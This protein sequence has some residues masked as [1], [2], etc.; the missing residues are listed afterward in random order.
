MELGA[1]IDGVAILG[2]GLDGWQQSRR[3]LS[4]AIPYHSEP[5]MIPPA[6]SLPAAERRRTGRVV[7]LALAVGFEAIAATDTDPTK[8][9]TVFASSGADS[10]NCHEICQTLASAD[11]QLSPT[12][13]HNSVHNVTAGYWSI[14]TRDMAASTVICAYDASFAAGLIEALT[15]VVTARADVLLIAYDMEYPKP[16]REK[17]PI[18]DSFAVALL[19]RP[20]PSALTLASIVGSL[21]SE[22]VEQLGL[23]ELERL[24]RDVPAARSLPLLASMTAGERRIT[25]L[26][27]L[28]PFCLTLEVTPWR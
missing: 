28:E 26:E 21:G 6:T 10:S 14:A 20:T 25:R 3:V 1:S 2:P 17:R 7:N 16:L 8:L 19:F 12:R 18:T 24:R 22:P 27:Y 11:R 15:Q 13:F 9:R 4:G 5:T 23:P